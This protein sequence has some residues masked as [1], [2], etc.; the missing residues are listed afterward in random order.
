MNALLDAFAKAKQDL[1][2]HVG[3]TEDWVVY[4]IDNQTDHFWS[5]ED[6]VIKFADS[7]EQFESDGDYYCG[8]IYTQRFYD[9]HVYRGED[10]TMVFNDTGVDGMK[11]FTFF[12]NKK[13]VK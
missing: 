8:E 7:M 4:P 2:R 10:L 13:E 1:Y 9:K 5:V 6:C 11:Y 3:F 12:D